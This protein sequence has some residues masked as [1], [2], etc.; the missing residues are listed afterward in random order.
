VTGVDPR[1]L[2]VAGAVATVLAATTLS[3]TYSSGRF[4]PPVAVAVALVAAVGIFARRVGVPAALVPGGQGVAALAYVVVVFAGGT[5]VGGVLPGRRTF[6]ALQ[7]LVDAG[8]HDISALAAPVDVRR[9]LLLLT[10]SGLCAVAI[11]VDTLAAG[12][13]RPALAGLPLLAVVAV[14]AAVVPSGVGWVSFALAAMGYLGLLLAD[15]R[16]RAVR[17]GRPISWR[18]MSAPGR[19]PEPAP[20]PGPV[21]PGRLGSRIGAAAVV[22]AVA[23]PALLPG[24]HGRF[25]GTGAGLGGTSGG[26]GNTTTYNPI[27]QLQGQLLETQARELLRVST[28]DP[29]PGYL[30]MTALDRFDGSTWSAT[31]LVAPASQRVTKGLP[32]VPGLAATTAVTTVTASVTATELSVPWLP[33]GYPPSKIS[34]S[35]DWR[36]DE[37]TRTI[38]STHA[39]TRDLSYKVT[40]TR[41]VASVDQLDVDAPLDPSL[42][43]YLQLPPDLPRLVA[44]TVRRVTAGATTRYAKAVA[45]QAYFR[46]PAFSYDLKVPPGNGDDALVAFLQN[47]RG[48]CE[49]FASAMAVMARVAGIPARVAI[50]F[51]AGAQTKPGAWSVTTHDA[52]SWPE[53]FFPGV[54]WLAFEP[55][56]IGDGRGVTP[57]YSVPAPAAAG[58]DAAGAAAPAPADDTATLRGQRPDGADADAG[59][60]G[61]GASSTKA[62]GGFSAA[63]RLAAGAVL[64][65]LLLLAAPWV[66]RRLVRWRRWSTVASPVAAAHAAWA[67]LLDDAADAGRSV[68]ANRSPRAV[69]VLLEPAVVGSDAAR[70]A[71]RAVADAEERARYAPTMPALGDLRPAVAAV[72]QGLLDAGSSRTRRL[73]VLFPRSAVRRAVSVAAGLVADGLDAL[74]RIGAA[75]RGRW[76]EAKAR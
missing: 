2:T 50:G 10:V 36:Y 53:L 38:F 4:L 48:F 22:V 19:G 76:Q 3:S 11:A 21:P 23:I 44:S 30:R 43:A 37:R 52:H 24:M 55:T 41:P 46:S 7:A 29:S 8:G 27:T 67:E 42:N 5:L 12:L 71:L 20:L 75:A 70:S 18:K 16:D 51:T 60:A 69:A 73:A 64:L 28:S 47:R 39:N 40:T 57:A 32:A 14:P 25:P 26:V 1:R 9:G 17:W 58:S 54:G 68:P 63:R 72:R 6:A 13:R 65:T 56:P 15:G 34:V 61:V 33:V 45:L 35:G 49:Q 62:G 31:P 74:D 59:S 66:G